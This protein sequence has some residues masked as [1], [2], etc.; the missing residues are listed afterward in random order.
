MINLHHGDC[1]EVLQN[2]PDNSVDSVVT[3]PPYSLTD[4]REE[5][6]ASDMLRDSIVSDAGH[7][8]AHLAEQF[9]PLRVTGGVPLAPVVFSVDLDAK[10]PGRDQEVN[11]DAAPVGQHSEPLVDVSHTVS[12]EQSSGS[13]FRLWVRQGHARC[14]GACRCLRK[15]SDGRIRVPVR[16]RYDPPRHPQRSAG[17]VTG[18]ATE[19]AAVLALD[20]GG[21]ATEL[22]PASGADTLDPAFEIRS[23]QPVGTLA[24][25]CGL[26]TVLESGW[27]SE[28]PPP[29]GGAFTFNLLVHRSVLSWRPSTLRGFMASLWDGTGIE[30]DVRLWRECLRVLRPGG[31]LLAFGGTRTYHR[32]ACAI[33][34][35]GFQIRD[36]IT[37][38][39]PW[40][41]DATEAALPQLSWVYG[42]GFP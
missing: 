5:N 3:D 7:D 37:H 35:A 18:T 21:G 4:R 42:S 14:V 16:V 11:G 17:V 25:A 28:V 15:G 2:L 13:E 9:I 31:H 22:L 19:L 29:T 36:R 12:S 39:Y 8:V 10:S 33:E 38:F 6:C 1:L 27:V 23:S 41:G 26:P 24:G 20:V 30:T 34:D 40:G 32:V